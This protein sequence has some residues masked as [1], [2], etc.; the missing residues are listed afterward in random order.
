MSFHPD[1]YCIMITGKNEDRYKYVEIA[2]RN[3]NMQTYSNKHL[4][5]I[6]HGQRSCIARTFT[7]VT[8]VMFDKT[9]FTLGDMRNYSLDLVPL[10]A[11]W[12]IW[13]DDDWRH[14][15]YLEMLY[16]HMSSKKADALFFQN[17]LDINLRNGFVYRAKFEKGMPFVMAKKCE[18]I[19]YLPKES[20]EDIRLHNDFELYEKKITVIANN[21]RWY[22]R[23]IHGNN[24]SLYVDNGKKEIVHYSPESLYHEFDAT[25]GEK[26]YADKIIETYFRNVIH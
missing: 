3:F 15:K 26:S 21:P 12:T 4:I 24:T 1:I 20:L 10:N 18:L 22:I 5:I 16:Q 8:E 9:N 23:T 6:N 14:P 13:D 17:R 2:L 11:I 7:N 19:Q 25:L